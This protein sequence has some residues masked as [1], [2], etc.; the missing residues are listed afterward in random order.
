MTK[1]IKIGT[2]LTAQPSR[3]VTLQADRVRH[4]ISTRLGAAR[5]AALPRFDRM[6]HR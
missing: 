6:D 2:D 1:T 3:A 5:A 4:L